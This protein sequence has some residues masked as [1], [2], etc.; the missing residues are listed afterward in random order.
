M[1]HQKIIEMIQ[2][3]PLNWTI[4]YNRPKHWWIW[5][6]STS[7]PTK[8]GNYR[9]LSLQRLTTTNPIP[10]AAGISLSF[11][12]KISS[13]MSVLPKNVWR[14]TAR[15]YSGWK[16]SSSS[17]SVIHVEVGMTQKWQRMKCTIASKRW[18]LSSARRRGIASAALYT[19]A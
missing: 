3:R 19:R 18:R 8:S 5:P 4:Y 2:F 13:A 6:L 16:T 9:E 10:S 12:R 15:L 1:N 11:S 7:P 14:T 17:K